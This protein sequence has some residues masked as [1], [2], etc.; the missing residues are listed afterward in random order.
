[1]LS[2]RVERGCCPCRWVDARVMAKPATCP[3]LAASS[4]RKRR[5]LPI[6]PYASLSKG[7]SSSSED[8]TELSSEYSET[9]QAKMGGSLTYEHERGMNFTRILPNLIVGSCLQTAADAGRLRLEENV[10]A[11]LC[12]QQ[13]SDMDYFDLDLDPVLEGCESAGITHI[14]SRVN[15][16]DPYD[17]RLK[18]PAAVAALHEEM[19]ALKEGECAYVHCTAGMG[20]AP[21]VAIAYMYWILGMPLLDAHRLLTTKRPC[22]P[23]L[24]AIR[25]ATCDLL[26]GLDRS[27]VKIGIRAPV[28]AKEVLVAG[29]DMGWDNAQACVR[30]S[31]NRFV[32]ERSLPAGRFMYKV[33]KRANIPPSLLPSLSLSLSV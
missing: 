27:D 14:R 8:R 33:R 30:E 22:N 28:Q 10:K 6:P 5:L 25:Q 23:K 16:F 9:M 20:R 19:R 11:V 15:D 12:L 7:S 24:V 1:M 21:G 17:L 31:D 2:L 4:P 26:F 13:D 32:L 18:L 29:L 3:P